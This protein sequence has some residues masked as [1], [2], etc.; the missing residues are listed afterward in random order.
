MGIV[1]AKL[2]ASAAGQL[3][4]MC[5]PGICTGGTETTVLAHA[6]SEVKGLGNKSHDLHASFSCCAC[7]DALDQRRIPRADAEFYWRRG[8]MRT[9]SIWLERGL[10]FVAGVDPDKPKKRPGKKAKIAGRKLPSRPFPSQRGKLWPQPPF[11][12]ERDHDRSE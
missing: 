12:E 8:M 3:C 2:R 9:Q 5:I 7:H 1:S 11:D 6:P 10:I 4:Q